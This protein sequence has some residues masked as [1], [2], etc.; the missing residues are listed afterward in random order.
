MLLSSLLSR[1]YAKNCSQVGVLT[2][3]CI[4]LMVTLIFALLRVLIPQ[5]GHFLGFLYYLVK[6]VIRDSSHLC[7]ILS[8]ASAGWLFDL[9]HCSISVYLLWNFLF[10]GRPDWGILA[11]ADFIASV[12]LQGSNC[13][14][15]GDS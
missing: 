4:L 14:Y 1:P 13:L 6:N 8:S 11:P 2:E 10:V 5:L 3:T 9:S 7:S 15:R 12:V